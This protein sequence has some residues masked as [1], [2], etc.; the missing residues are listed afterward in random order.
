MSL[1]VRWSLA[2]NQD[3]NP[4]CF[5]Y[6]VVCF[7]QSLPYVLEAR[8]EMLTRASLQSYK[9]MDAFRDFF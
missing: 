4:P 9:K 8:S 2:L 7:L 1:P 6:I 3:I 5:R